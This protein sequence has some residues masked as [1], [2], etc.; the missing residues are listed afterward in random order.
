MALKLTGNWLDTMKMT[1]KMVQLDFKSLH[2]EIGEYVLNDTRDRFITGRGPDGVRW[3]KSGRVKQ[4]GGKTLVHKRKLEGSLTFKALINRV[5]IGTNDKR[6]A[7]HHFGG[8]I[9]ARGGGYLRFKIG[10]QWVQVKSVTIPARPY[11]GLNKRN[12]R[13]I[14]AIVARRIGVI[15]RD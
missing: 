10:K 14:G 15:T 5:E 8:K 4:R 1:K 12:Q 7:I 9:K 2:R 6:A 13:E 3:P 11:L